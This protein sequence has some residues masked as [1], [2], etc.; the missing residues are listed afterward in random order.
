M[1]FEFL[2]NPLTQS[3][4]LI[5]YGTAIRF[6]NTFRYRAGT[7]VTYNLISTYFVFILSIYTLVYPTKDSTF[8]KSDSRTYVVDNN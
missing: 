6:S 2:W 8:L 4:N 7:F 5:S 1:Y 3:L